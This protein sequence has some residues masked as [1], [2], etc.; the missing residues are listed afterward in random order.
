[1]SKL[2]DGSSLTIVQDGDDVPPRPDLRTP[3]SELERLRRNA[4]SS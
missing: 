3:R 2:G 1:M 4:Q